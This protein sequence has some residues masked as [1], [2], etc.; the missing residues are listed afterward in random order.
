MSTR[1]VWRKILNETLRSY[2][3]WGD[4]LTGGG[5]GYTVNPSVDKVEICENFSVYIDASNRV[6]FKPFGSTTVMAP[7]T[8]NIVSASAS[9]QYCLI[10]Y[11][12]SSGASSPTIIL[13]RGPRTNYW[14]YVQSGSDYVVT[15]SQNQQGAD[16]VPV[17]TYYMGGV[18]VENV[19]EKATATSDHLNTYVGDDTYSYYYLGFDNI[20]PIS[21]TYATSIEYQGEGSAT[22]LPYTISPSKSNTYGGMIEY[23][24]GYRINGGNWTDDT[25]WRTSTTSNRTNF[26][27][28]ATYQF[29]VRARDRWG[30]TS[31]TYI[32]GPTCTVTSRPVIFLLVSPVNSGTTTGSGEY[33]SGSSATVKAVPA[34]GWEFVAWTENGS[35][36]STS[37]FYTFTVTAS[38]N[39]TAV[40]KQK[41]AAWVGVSNKARKGVDL[42]VGVNGKARKVTAAY[43]GVN[44]K[45][46]RFL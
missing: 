24:I 3:T 46:R 25:T 45:A 6:C 15:T 22:S 9:T 13:M 2:L 37:A 19:P 32:T 40:F 27:Q 14:K 11:G 7:T 41:L 43:I 10:T 5:S 36:V 8:N 4:P 16:S 29:R 42:Y 33:N 18:S 35:T 26:E 38:R 34:E 44:G 30:F 28:G 12:V 17:S 21:I 20:D 23:N 39:L 31:T 1:Y